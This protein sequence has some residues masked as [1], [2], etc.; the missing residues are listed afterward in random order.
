MVHINIHAKC[1]D[2]IR[3]KSES[4]RVSKK[5]YN[6]FTCIHS[7]YPFT[8]IHLSFGWWKWWKRRIWRERE[9]TRNFCYSIAYFCHGI[10][11]IMWFKYESMWSLQNNAHTNSMN[12]RDEICIER[13]RNEM[14]S[15]QKEQLITIHNGESHHHR[16][17][18]RR[19]RRH[20][21]YSSPTFLYGRVVVLEIDS[22]I[23]NYCGTYSQKGK[24]KGRPRA[25]VRGREK[26]SMTCD[27]FFRNVKLLWILSSW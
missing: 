7:I 3:C 9:Q 8:F 23:H 5:H 26:R 2:Q 12:Q 15:T 17:W 20:S 13:V 6:S 11:N 27:Y 10:N 4:S 21:L 24:T 18:C 19:R 22:H 1:P 14:Q 25:R 16:C